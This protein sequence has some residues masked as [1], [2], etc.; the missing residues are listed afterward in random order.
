[1]LPTGPQLRARRVALDVSLTEIAAFLGISVPYLWDLEHGHRSMDE[2]K[3]RRYAA[4]LRRVEER[5]VKA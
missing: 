3:R 2:A 4:A 5:K 1:M